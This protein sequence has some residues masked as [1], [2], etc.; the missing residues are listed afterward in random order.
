MLDTDLEK[1][2]LV[3]F[4]SKNNWGNPDI[5]VNN[6]ERAALIFEEIDYDEDGEEITIP[7]EETFGFSIEHASIIVS[8]LK[9]GYGYKFFKINEDTPSYEIL[10]IINEALCWSYGEWTSPRGVENVYKMRDNGDVIDTRTQKI[11]MQI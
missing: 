5:E 10:N 8:A 3:E 9:D 4:F 7:I 1:L 11:L 2:E 6:I